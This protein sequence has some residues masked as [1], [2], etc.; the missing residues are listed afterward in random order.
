MTNPGATSALDFVD[1]PASHQSRCGAGNQACVRAV[2]IP[3]KQ[4]QSYKL[5]H[6]FNCKFPSTMSLRGG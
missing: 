2:A 3:S 1:A 4:S 5:L 6:S